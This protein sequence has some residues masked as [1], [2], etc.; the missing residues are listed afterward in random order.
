MAFLSWQERYC[1][2]N[3]ELD[4]Q[5]KNLFELVNRFDDLIQAGKTSELGQIL[6][7]TIS[8]SVAHFLSEEALI[9]KMG[10]PG[11]SDHKKV[12]DDLIE[13]IQAMRTRM[14]AG[15][16]VSQKAIVRFLADWLTNHILREDMEYKP[17]LRN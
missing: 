10:F 13:Q 3:T 16:S 17:Y 5:H 15:G 4:S 6:D 11:V 12:H 8:C 14:K 1:V 2:G 9:Q 7:D